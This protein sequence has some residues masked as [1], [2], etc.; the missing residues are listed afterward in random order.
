MKF[1]L[2]L[3]VV[4][5]LAAGGYYAY[6]QGLLDSLLGKDVETTEETSEPMAKSEP[7]VT[8]KEPG[9]MPDKPAEPE[10]DPEVEKRLEE[11]YPMP[12]FKPLLVLVDNWNNVPE[13]AFPKAVTLKVPV[14]FKLVKDGQEIGS[15]ETPAGTQVVPLKHKPGQL[16]ISDHPQSTMRAVVN[17][18]DTDF[19]EL[20]QVLYDDKVAEARQ[21]VIS[22]RNV[23]RE[24]ISRPAEE[25]DPAT[26]ADGWHD[27]KDPRFAPVWAHL[28]SGEFYSALPEE[29]KRW[30]WLGEEYHEGKEYDVV[31]VD[32]EIET[33]FGTF[34]NTMKCLLDHGKVVKWID[35]DSGDVRT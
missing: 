31:L 24:V 21:R 14:T 4:G 28:R 20:I 26:I 27:P 1:I 23:A 12:N 22:A 8:K 7:L 2:I 29:A 16:L 35:A 11:Q 17:V 6:N 25:G 18:D 34:P 33:I 19:K 13:R 5:G 10:L 15:R 9:T 3:L 32:F 30:R